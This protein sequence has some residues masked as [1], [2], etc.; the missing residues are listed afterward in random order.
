MRNQKKTAGIKNLSYSIE[1]EDERIEKERQARR[2][3]FSKG[4]QKEQ[5][6]VNY[7]RSIV[8]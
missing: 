8:R 4:N 7:L 3:R 6:K 2:E 1:R 5:S